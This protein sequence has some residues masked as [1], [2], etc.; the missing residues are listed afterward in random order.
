MEDPESPID[1]QIQAIYAR[2]HVLLTKNPPEL[3]DSAHQLWGE[4]AKLAD[5]PEISDK[6]LLQ[7]LRCAR[8]WGNP[9]A[10]EL[11]RAQRGVFSAI[12]LLHGLTRYLNIYPKLVAPL[13]DW[14]LWATLHPHW[15]RCA[16]PR[17]P[18]R[19]EHFAAYGKWEGEAREMYAE[20][21]SLWKR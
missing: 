8:G 9:R 19:E 1:K 7:E 10:R 6:Q 5:H 15:S 13:T 14:S 11:V 21:S 12:P 18:L 4:I 20:W 16:P 2:I 17:E 3:M